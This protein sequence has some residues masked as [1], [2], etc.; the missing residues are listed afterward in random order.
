M[1]YFILLL[2]I[3]SQENCKIF[4]LG[5]DNDFLIIYLILRSKK[6]FSRQLYKYSNTVAA[7]ILNFNAT[8]RNIDIDAF[9]KSPP[10]CDCASSPFRYAPHGHFITGDFGIIPNEDLKRLLLKG[11]NCRER[12]SINWGYNM[13][14]ILLPLRTMQKSGQRKKTRNTNAFRTGYSM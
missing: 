5:Q 6:I 8:V 1:R 3:S 7:K 12:T 9:I 13:K 14:L 2:D 10:S 4:C 11:P